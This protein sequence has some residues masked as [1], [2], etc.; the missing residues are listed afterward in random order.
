MKKKVMNFFLQT[1][2]KNLNEDN[3]I[4]VSKFCHAWND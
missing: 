3:S 1:L 2:Y 4:V